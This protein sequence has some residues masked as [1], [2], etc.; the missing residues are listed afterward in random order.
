MIRVIGIGGAPATG[1][2]TV[3]QSVMIA[4]GGAWIENQMGALAWVRNGR[5]RIVVLGQYA[6]TSPAHW[7]ADRLSMAAQPKALAT[8]LSWARDPHS[9]GLVVLFEGDRF[10]HKGFIRA[11]EACPSIQAHWI[12]LTA[13]PGILTGRHLKRHR[14]RA[15][16]HFRL[17]RDKAR[18]LCEMF[19][20]IE[21]AR[22][23]QPPDTET[24]VRHVL[25]LIAAPFPDQSYR[26]PEGSDDA[27]PDVTPALFI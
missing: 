15:E 13:A 8:L 6:M 11:I 7:G 9:H 10:F 21:Q 19:P 18:K 4:V 22:C 16:S 5:Y 25:D 14:V 3:M 2:S 24:V 26:P 23:E 17:A 20:G 12:M 1:K 27:M